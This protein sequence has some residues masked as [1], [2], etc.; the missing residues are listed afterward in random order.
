M[1]RTTA[2]VA[3][4]SAALA[5]GLAVALVL[6]GCGGSDVPDPEPGATDLSADSPDL[7]ADS[8]DL[9]ETTVTPRPGMLDV[10]PVRIWYQIETVDD[11]TMLLTFPSQGPPCEVL[12]RFEVDETDTRLTITLYHGRDPDAG[13]PCDGGPDRVFAVE[14]PLSRPFVHEVDQLING[15]SLMNR[16]DVQAI[17]TPQPGML[18]VQPV[19]WWYDYGRDNLHD[20]LV[21]YA[22]Q[23]P[24]C[25]VLDRI[26]VDETGTQA[27]VTLYQGRDPDADPADPCDGPTQVVGVE[28]P[29]TR[30]YGPA[31][32]SPYILA[33]ITAENGEGPVVNGGS[34]TDSG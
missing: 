28:V 6:G 8:T 33:G 27:I 2:Q 32:V 4:K 34:L 26:E 10:E 31:G 24:P 20:M 9:A 23:G 11:H 25:E 17:V 21:T 29:L 5:L 13:E 16:P 7:S 19:R 14:V 1:V 3:A 18:D 22:S 15:G 12:D 30:D